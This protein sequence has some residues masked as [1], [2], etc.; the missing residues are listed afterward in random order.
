MREKTGKC[1]HANVV[2]FVYQVNQHR[3]I[4]EFIQKLP[5]DAARIG[6]SVF[7]RRNGYGAKFPAARAGR[8]RGGRAFGADA[9]RIGSVFDVASRKYLS[10]SVK[11]AAPTA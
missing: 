8:L 11:T 5:A 7:C 2:F 9:G 6:E 10:A 1:F 4:R 3:F